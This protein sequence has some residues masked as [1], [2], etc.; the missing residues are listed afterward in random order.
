MAAAQLAF[1]TQ[2]THGSCFD[3]HP[4]QRIDGYSGAGHDLVTMVL[5]DIASAS[6]TRSFDFPVV[7]HERQDARTPSLSQ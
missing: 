3:H 5:H 4:D 6:G 1:P 7:P 2:L